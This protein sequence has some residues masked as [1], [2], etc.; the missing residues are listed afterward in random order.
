MPCWVLICAIRGSRALRDAL[1]GCG[2]C[3]LRRA[4]LCSGEI[5]H[6]AGDMRAERAEWGYTGLRR[7]ERGA[8]RGGGICALSRA[9]RER[10]Y[11]ETKKT[12]SYPSRRKPLFPFETL[13]SCGRSLR[14]R[15]F[16]WEPSPPFAFHRK[17][18]ESVDNLPKTMRKS[19]RR[20]ADGMSVGWRSV[21]RAV[22]PIDYSPNF[23]SQYVL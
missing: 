2:I 12:T 13:L 18:C 3:A 20:R 16:L 23:M 10:G 19:E 1:C 11:I 14:V 15:W 17:G 7:A 22:T 5:C 8:E 4:G 21:I 9:E 6:T